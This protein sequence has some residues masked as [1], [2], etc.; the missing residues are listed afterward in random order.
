MVAIS[1][2]A[3]LLRNSEP[4]NDWRR[5]GNLPHLPFMRPNFWRKIDSKRYSNFDSLFFLFL[6]LSGLHKVS[7]GGSRPLAFGTTQRIS[8]IRVS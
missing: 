2:R 3:P 7:S 5:S 1:E 4:L 6:I 8:E